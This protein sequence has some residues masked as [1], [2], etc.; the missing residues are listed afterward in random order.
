MTFDLAEARAALE[1]GP[2]V[3]RALVADLPSPWLAARP[4]PDDWDAHAVVCHLVYVE[5]WDWLV[6]ARMIVE[7]GPGVP[8]P[9]V[10]H[11]DQTDRYPGIATAE[12]AERFEGLRTANLAELDA[13]GIGPDDL[14]RTG[15][16]PTLGEVT[17]RQLIATWVVHDHNHL[18]Q[19]Q[20]ALAAH[21]VD[22]VGPWRAFLGV[23]DR[24]TQ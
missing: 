10:E 14:D 18:R 6:R 19:L 22:E 9:P 24:V 1:R 2:S 7:V 11:R 17:L 23:L 4:T 3:L 16:H 5:E 8:F 21:Y 13:R 20:E 15:M 12:L